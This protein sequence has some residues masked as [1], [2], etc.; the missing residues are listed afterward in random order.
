MNITRKLFGVGVTPQ[1]GERA[2]V[3]T[4]VRWGLQFERDG[5]VSMAY[6]ETFLDISELSN[7]KPIDELTKEQIIQWAFDKDNGDSIIATQ[8]EHHDN[9]LRY[10]ALQASV[11]EYN[12]IPLDATHG[13]LGSPSE[14][15]IPQAV[16]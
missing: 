9:T 8:W 14:I 10:E 16:L 6:I 4:R 3:V 7:F 11:T 5:F 15:T 2:N 12:G 1:S 13:A